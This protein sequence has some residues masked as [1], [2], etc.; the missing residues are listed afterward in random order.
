LRDDLYCQGECMA[1]YNNLDSKEP[2]DN[3][4]EIQDAAAHYS[5]HGATLC[6]IRYGA[7]AFL[8][9]LDE[10]AKVFT[11]QT[12]DD[13][14]L[15]KEGT[16][17]KVL[18][19][20][21]EECWHELVELNNRGAGIFVTVNETDGR[22]RKNENIVGVRAIFQDDDAGFQGAYPLPPSIEVMSS[23][24]KFQRYWLCSGVTPEE[25][26]I[27]LDRLT[28]SYGS[29][30]KA[31]GVARVLR[32]PG[33]YHLK[34]PDDPHLVTLQPSPGTVYGAEE[35][36]S[37]FLSAEAVPVSGTLQRAGRAETVQQSTAKNALAGEETR[38]I[39]QF[40][41]P[42][43]QSV[44]RGQSEQERVVSA[45][46]ALPQKFVDERNLWRDIGMALYS[47]GLPGARSLFDEWSMGS[48]KFGGGHGFPGS[49]KYDKAGQETFWTSLSKDFNGPKITLKTL[50]YH[51]RL[52]GWIDPKRSCH[53]TDLGNAQRLVDRHGLNL[54]YV[55]EW[56]KWL[57]WRDGRWNVDTSFEIERLAKETVEAM[58]READ[59][60]ASDDDRTSLRK[61]ALKSE[62]AQR[63]HA[64]IVLARSEDGVPISASLLDAQSYLLGLH[65]GVIDLRTLTFREG[66]R[67]DYI[68]KFCGTHYDPHAKCPNWLKFLD[69][70]MDENQE[71][72]DYLR[73][74]DG[75]GLTGSVAEEVM[76]ILWG[77]GKNGKSTYRETKRLLLGDYSDTAGVD[78]LLQKHD[79]G[80][81][82]PQMAKLKGLRHISIN[83][84]RE[85]GKLSEERLKNLT[86]NEQLEA[87][88]LNQNPFTFMPTHKTDLTTNH[89][90]VIAGTDEGI[91]RRIH[92]V[93]FTITIPEE[94]RDEHY[95]ENYL[96]P[97]LP[98]ILNWMLK[99]LNEYNKLGL[100]PPKE[101]QAA[102]RAYRTEMDVI[103]QWLDDNCHCLPQCSQMLHEL[104]KNYLDYVSTEF[105]H[106]GVTLSKRKFGYALSDRGFETDR[107]TGG[108]R[109]RK[110]LMLKDFNLGMKEAPRQGV[111]L[112]EAFT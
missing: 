84:T 101:I 6:Q 29:D 57:I 10:N 45:L 15:R 97:E 40:S 31:K 34:D 108:G 112:E 35:L 55:V 28:D 23:P 60:L 68:T 77:K 41:S 92:L 46:L 21:L 58:W 78:V 94:E 20:S 26:K 52:H 103:E 59:K 100:N 19:G 13:D 71:I 62:A 49:P 38:R 33:F 75:Y 66:R 106:A 44:D 109:I 22:G 82:T 47:S 87:R 61:H 27:F 16:L 64:M 48:E 2:H 42:V 73:R 99:G 54:R 36:R 72:I 105:G 43:L 12:F 107:G 98:G 4:H 93:P 65:N 17:A 32:L 18:H 11:F 70:I 85:N 51:A 79:A 74:F 96:M 102:T 24:G 39:E 5:S 30:P 89:K 25:F 90:P 1:Y 69:R 91:W 88:F 80:A 50:F 81:A 63:I 9:L 56:G 104:H 86:S 8:Q 67:E 7:E 110:G 3:V 53:H 95:R 37:A 76:R 14:K 83:E 111:S